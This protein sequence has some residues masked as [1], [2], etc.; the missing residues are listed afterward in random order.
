M[1]T[2][3]NENEEESA[4]RLTK[5]EVMAVLRLSQK[6]LERRMRDRQIGYEKDGRHVFFTHHDLQEYRQSRKV[7]AC[8]LPTR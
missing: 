7:R 3:K 2:V 8:G 4:A 1:T 6:S 5:A